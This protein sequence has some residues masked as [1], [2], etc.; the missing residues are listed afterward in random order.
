MPLLNILSPCFEI[1]PD[2]TIDWHGQGGTQNA[3]AVK[4]LPIYEQ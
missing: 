3:A 4:N 2:K 1:Y